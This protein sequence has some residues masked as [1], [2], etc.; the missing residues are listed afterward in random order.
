[1]KQSSNYRDPA[2]LKVVESHV[3]S[4]LSND[5]RSVETSSDE[6]LR[7]WFKFQQT[8]RVG[9][10]RSKIWTLGLAGAGTAGL[11]FAAVLVVSPK[12]S[13]NSDDSL[14]EPA[15]L[16]VSSSKS[17]DSSS[18]LEPLS[19]DTKLDSTANKAQPVLG[20][21]TA[22]VKKTT[23]QI[24]TASR[25]ET[26]REAVSPTVSAARVQKELDSHWKEVSAAL[27]SGNKVAAEQALQS[28]VAK[29]G[30]GSRES[31]QLALAQIWLGM[32]K[33][34]DATALLTKLRDS[35]QQESVRVS[36]ASALK[37]Q[38]KP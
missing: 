16:A 32:G 1:M 27:A 11:A 5:W 21:G 18:S 33:R 36:A 9:V 8:S 10:R 6:V 23:G 2:A 38:T 25:K 20:G 22:E 15:S 35:A 24:S 29:T 3:E 37:R 19:D 7:Q 34:A 17:S 26:L 14:S 30:G 28:I 31:A 13:T 4:A 12:W